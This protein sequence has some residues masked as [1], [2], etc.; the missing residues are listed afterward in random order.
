LNDERIPIHITIGINADSP[1]MTAIDL[2]DTNFYTWMLEAP[3]ECHAFL[4]KITSRFIEVETEF[5][6]IAGRPMH[7]GLSYSD[8]SAQIIALDQ[9][10]E[11]CT[12]RQAAL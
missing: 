5:R 7:D 8:D 2:V 3:E 1:F 4:G 10:R 9:Y 12:F 11:F 6:K